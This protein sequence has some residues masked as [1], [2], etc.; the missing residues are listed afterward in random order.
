MSKFDFKNT[1]VFPPNNLNDACNS[2]FVQWFSGE[3]VS[4]YRV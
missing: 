1:V 3:L 4:Y 2:T